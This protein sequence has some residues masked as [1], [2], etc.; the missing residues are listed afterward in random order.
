MADT[1][2][3]R[4]ADGILSPIINVFAK[5]KKRLFLTTEVDEQNE[6]AIDIFFGEG[7]EMLEARAIETIVLEN[8]P[9]QKQ[10][11]PDVALTI[12]IDEDK[13]CDIHVV[14][15]G[16]N[17]SAGK[18]INLR[19]TPQLEDISEYKSSTRV[20]PVEKSPEDFQSI[21]P[22]DEDFV[23][24]IDPNVSYDLEDVNR[25]KRQERNKKIKKGIKI[26]LFVLCLLI[27]IFGLLVLAFFVFLGTQILPLPPLFG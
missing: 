20:N 13:M 5:N 2:A 15:E 9:Q 21:K 4:L 3:I 11:E 22:I 27:S 25:E 19:E 26:N 16:T 12:S 7:R 14:I 18:T 6:I 23:L 24:G 8:I 1:I 10:G 17:I